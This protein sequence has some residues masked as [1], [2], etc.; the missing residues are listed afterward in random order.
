MPSIAGRS[1]LTRAGG[2]FI[3]HLFRSRNLGNPRGQA[4]AFPL[5]V[6]VSPLLGRHLTGVARLAGRLIEALSRQVEL[7]L[8]SCVPP[9]AA[10]GKDVLPRL[11]CGEE[12]VIP[13]NTLPAADDDLDG[14]V[15]RLFRR[16]LRPHDHEL[17][18]QTTGLFTVLR[19]V[20]RHFRRELGV[21]HDFTPL[22]LPWTHAPETRLNFGR[23]FTETVL[24]CDKMIANSH[25][26]KFD[27]GW[28]TALAEEDIVVGYPGPTLCVDRH[29]HTHPVARRDNVIL[30]V[31]TLEPRKNGRFL[32]D[33]FLETSLLAPGHELWWVGPNG[34]WTPQGWLKDLTDRGQQKGPRGR[35]VKFLGVVPDHVLCRLY[36][37]AT[38]TVYPS[39]YEGFGFPVLDA[40]RHGTPVL[41]S[42]NSSLQEF[43]GPGVFYFDPWEVTTLDE[44][45]REL[46]ATRGSSPTLRFARDDLDARFSWDGMARTVL[47]L[48]A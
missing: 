5:Y 19:P 48:C 43:A 6:E 47:A 15:D 4:V 33:W 38:F 23:F 2:H 32:L 46:I 9:G 41:A 37:Q 18:R 16:P 11:L 10:T 27:A 3:S 8:F 44:A 29:A 17:A 36:Q 7:R 22:L 45:C 14:W 12:I 1:A 21:F 24:L 40:L 35:N 31:S 39:L 30:V 25:S 26:T 34:W 28:L 20:Q 13:R 42:C